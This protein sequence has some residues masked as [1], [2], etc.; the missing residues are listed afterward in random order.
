MSK[1]KRVRVDGK[2]IPELVIRKCADGTVNL[3]LDGR[4]SVNANP[5]LANQIA[6]LAANAIAIGRGYSHA[7][8]TYRDALTPKGETG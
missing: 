2:I 3:I 5:E 6:W 1:R 8:A 4:F 7:G